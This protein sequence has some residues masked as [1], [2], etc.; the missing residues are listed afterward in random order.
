MARP[1]K[2]ENAVR[3]DQLKIRLTAIERAE[4]DTKAEAVGL[5]AVDYVRRL[6]LGHRLPARPQI[7]RQRHAEA[8]TAL[9]RLGV[10]LNQ[11]A[12][13]V[14]MDTAG[15]LDLEE[16]GRLMAR[17]DGELNRLEGF[18]EDGEDAETVAAEAEAWAARDPTR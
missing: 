3:D 9:L 11:I 5:S 12:K 1:R 16:L 6:A 8:V 18:G 15:P 14:N 4:I 17:I 10:N 13:R 2:N 7:D